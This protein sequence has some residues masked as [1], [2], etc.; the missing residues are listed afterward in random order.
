MKCFTFSRSIVCLFV[1]SEIRNAKLSLP[2]NLERIVKET[3]PTNE[4]SVYTKI[5][6]RRS[7]DDD[8]GPLTAQDQEL[9]GLGLIRE[10]HC[11]VSACEQA[12]EASLDGKYLEQT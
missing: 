10:L 12:D 4:E 7:C 5:D 1:A 2:V 9:K 8:G 3:Y 6:R 11:N